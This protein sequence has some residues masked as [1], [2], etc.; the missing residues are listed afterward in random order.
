MTAV[1]RTA[2]AGAVPLPLDRR[3]VAGALGAAV[4]LGMLGAVL[5][6]L[7]AVGVLALGIVAG[8]AYRPVVATYVYLGTVPLIAGIER[9]TLIPLLRPNEALFALLFGGAVLGGYL[10]Y[11]QGARLSWRLHALDVPLAWFAVLATVWPLVSLLL[12]GEAVQQVHLVAVLPMLKLAAL[13][14]LVR[15]TVTDDASLLRCLR[16]V[17]WS[18]AVLALIAVLQTLQVGPVLALL[19]TFWAPDGSTADLAERG[20]ATLASPIATGDYIIISLVLVVCCGARGLLGHRERLLLGFVLGAGVL[21]AGQFSTWISAVVAVVLLAWR[22]P[23]LRRRSLRFLPLAPVAM[24]VGAPALI[25]RLEG[26]GDGFGVPRSWL[27]RWD[28][29]YNIYL[30]HL[31]GLRLLVGVSPDPTLPA[32]ETWR[33]FIYLES[34]YLQ[35]LWIGGVPLLLGFLWLT[36]TVF[37]SAAPFTADR[38]PV[39]AC[40]AAIVV[41][42]WFV[43][44]LSVID[45]HLTLRG[46]GELLFLLLAVIGARA[47]PAV[48]HRVVPGEAT[49]RALDVVVATVGL[50]VL[51]VPLL[52]IAVAIRLTSAGPALYKQ[53]RVG[54]DGK[55]FTMYKFRTMRRGAGDEALRDLIA[56]ELAGEDTTN[57]GSTKLAAPQVTGLGALLRRTSVD[58][59]P[60]LL[61]VLGGTMSLV[62]PRPCLEW[63]AR[64][65][66]AEF[67]DRFTVRPGLTGLWQVSGRSTKGT[68]DMLRFDLQYVRTRGFWSDV[69]ILLR[70]VLIVLRGDGAR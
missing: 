8:A 32:P 59:L 51:A 19:G 42:W 61:N 27:G 6:P 40:A 67:A 39:G 28:N 49:R 31:D 63:E 55:P 50:L 5:G 23:E 25:G 66:P 47:H 57:G 65:F 12:R 38:T 52:A 17:V 3:T 16:L 13:Y 58:E 11:L 34:G 20:S 9:G 45:P 70:T 18:G 33:D 64:L 54:L 68:L 35:F 60:Q 4:V 10:R 30:P 56:R 62:G 53:L 1:A 24:L 7:V 48:A 44:V 69:D 41:V 43:V 21:A 15:C 36:V 14:V 29:L 46:T 2:G 26:F 22:F 37:R